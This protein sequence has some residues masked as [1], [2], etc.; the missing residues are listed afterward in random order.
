[1]A[2]ADVYDA[3]CSRRV[4]KEGFS[5]EKSYGIILDGRG[6]HFDPVIFDAFQSVADQFNELR[7]QLK[8]E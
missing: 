7:E 1:M 3:L 2:L 5:H 8:P 4:Y 6:K